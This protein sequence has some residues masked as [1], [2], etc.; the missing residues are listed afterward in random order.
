M[1]HFNNSLKNRQKW[2]FFPNTGDKLKF[3]FSHP[4]NVNNKKTRNKRKQNTSKRQKKVEK[5]GEIAVE[6]LIWKL[7]TVCCL[8]EPDF[9]DAGPF[10]GKYYFE[11]RKINKY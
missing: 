1:A 9:F 8:R 2:L 5:S 7:H 4:E 11:H 6:R 10:G 3:R